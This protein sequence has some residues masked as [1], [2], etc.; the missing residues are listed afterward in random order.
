[1]VCGQAERHRR[2]S[3]AWYSPSSNPCSGSSRLSRSLPG[4]CVDA[5]H[6]AHECVCG[7]AECPVKPRGGSAAHFHLNF[8][9]AILICPPSHGHAQCK[10]RLRATVLAATQPW[11]PVSHP[12]VR[13]TQRHKTD[14]STTHDWLSDS[15]GSSWSSTSVL[16]GPV[17]T[18]P[19]SHI[20]YFDKY[21]TISNSPLISVVSSLPRLHIQKYRT[22]NH[23]S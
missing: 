12:A 16:K 1:M 5:P 14:L 8:S 23:R 22:T 18:Q 6:L 19:S 2:P 17:Y 20:V 4:F 21:N 13:A 3:Q 10:G 15:Y 9:C 11:A 7:L